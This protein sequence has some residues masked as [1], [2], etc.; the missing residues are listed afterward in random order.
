MT[1]PGR[2]RRGPLMLAVG[3]ALVSAPSPAQHASGGPSSRV[4]DPGMEGVV[5]GI[6][7]PVRD[8]R[9]QGIAIRG[10][11]AEALLEPAEGGACRVLLVA[12]GEPVE[13]TLLRRP[14]A[15]MDLVQDPSCPGPCIDQVLQGIASAGASIRFVEAGTGPR[16][17]GVPG[18]DPSAPE[19]RRPVPGTPLL[20]PEASLALSAILGL[21]L[22]GALLGGLPRAA[23]RILAWDHGWVL[24]VLVAGAGLVLLG[25]A[26]T[27]TLRSG[28]EWINQSYVLTATWSALNQ[29]QYPHPALHFEVLA[30]ANGLRALIH[31]VATS[32]GLLEASL[33]L[34]IRHPFDSILLARALSVL[35]WMGVVVV[36]WHL[37]TRF[38]GAWWTGLLAALVVIRGEQL[39]PSTLSPYPLGILLSILAIDLAWRDHRDTGTRG[40]ALPGLCMGAAIGTHYLAALFAPLA[41]LALFMVP[42][43]LAGKVRRSLRWGLWVAAGFLVTNPRLVLELP[44]Y[45]HFWHYRVRELYVFDPYNA[46]MRP[47]DS[48]ALSPAFYW[49]LFRGRDLRGAMLAGT[50]VFLVSSVRRRDPRSL[51]PVIWGLAPVVVLSLAATRYEHY[52]QFL[53]PGAA[54][55]GFAWLPRAMPD[56]PGPRYR[57]LAVLPLAVFLA[58]VPSLGHPPMAGWGRG[59]VWSDPFG[60]AA[61][62]IRSRPEVADRIFVSGLPMDVAGPVL[63]DRGFGAMMGREAASRLFREMGIRVDWRDVRAGGP[64]FVPDRPWI[65]IG[66][67]TAVP[68]PPGDRWRLA[69]WIQQG[70]LEFR[71]WVPRGEGP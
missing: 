20:G 31:S 24:L 58:H 18:F 44:N 65:T 30:A 13:G 29:G 8:C 62:W 28:D 69:D 45:L 53:L 5:R 47:A 68:A 50:L 32:Q 3:L 7:Q 48:R 36:T 66:E 9:V 60:A 4:L 33:D 64:G 34:A 67:V 1:P 14:G 42:G 12:P 41:V 56:F 23:R 49:D 35:S 26:L 22:A 17:G 70:G 38:G 37:A 61:T 25:E 21:V 46:W 71:L 54:V 11:V 2:L 55:L 6:F 27:A 19:G 57:T 16:G 51:F 15:R 10:G 52:L 39:Y 40:A 43:T 59:L 63:E